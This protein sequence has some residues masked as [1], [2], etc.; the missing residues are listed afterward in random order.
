MALVSELKNEIIGS[1]IAA[2][3]FYKKERTA[4]FIFKNN[5]RTA[6]AFGYHP[7][8]S[9]SYFVPASKL[10]ITTREKPWPILGMDNAE[11][12]A[13]E[14]VGFDRIFKIE[15]N[16]DNKKRII[17]FEAIGVNGNIWLLDE[18]ENKIGTLRNK[19]FE[20]KEK[21]YLAPV[22][23]KLNPFE[24]D[25]ESLFEK[26]SQQ[27]DMS[28]VRFIEKN[29]LGCS[30]TLA[31][32][33]VKRADL[34]N[35]RIDETDL[36]HW[37][38]ITESLKQ[39]ISFFESPQIGYLY[40]IG[41][42]FEAYPFKLSSSTTQPD[43][44]KT[45]SMA[46]SSMLE[47]AQDERVQVDEENIINGALRRYSKKLRKRLDKIESDLKDAADFEK[48]KKNGELLKI[49]FDKLKKGNEKI[50][51]V[52]IYTDSQ[53]K[54]TIKLE[55]SLSPHENAE[56]YF[57]KYRKGREGLALMER[58]Q[59]ITSQELLELKKMI[60]EFEYD[61]DSSRKKYEAELAS[62]LPKEATK[63]I[64]VERLPYKEYYLSTGLKIF[65]GRDGTDNDRTTFEF[66]KPY[67]LWFHTQQCAG[68]H[69]AIKF[70]NKNFEPSKQEIEET[71][72]IAAFHSKARKNSMVP[73]IY[74]QRKYVRKPRKAKPGLVLVEREKSVMVVPKK[75]E[76][77]K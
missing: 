49:N 70:P 32:E 58:R 30:F 33:I 63:Q 76:D 20:K 28:T 13:V 65:V 64:S 4:Y 59:E 73:V 19:K 23:G 77:N 72:A 26:A 9:G 46:I 10:R 75:P 35:L 44:Y 24:T 60:D 40:Q 21:Y 36:A 61:F 54:I 16:I 7:T 39:I 34:E 56:R 14:Q 69:V 55:K 17:L 2:T 53:E 48:Y 27:S 31:K 50:T 1:K 15:V 37:E 47:R 62:I 43:K 29:I 51:V 68:S 66:T 25:S 67:E 41:S 45:L 42:K 74:T 3:E 12:S 71:A 52:D 11:V 5:S 38:N 22:E 57:K 18:N 6:L 8:R